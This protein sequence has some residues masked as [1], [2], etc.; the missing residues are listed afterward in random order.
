MLALIAGSGA[1]PAEL[2]RHQPEPPLVCALEGYAPEALAVDIW[3]RIETLGSLLAMLRERWIDEVCMAGAIRRPQVDPARIDAATMPFV[4]RLQKAI[5]SGD[6]GAL[7]AVIAIFEEA[8]FAVRGAHE[9][10]PDILPPVGCL[11]ENQPG[12]QDLDDA[13]RAAGILRAMSVAD[14]GQACVVLRG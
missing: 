9:I 7:R 6:D 11:T 4:P 1:L 3:F 2:A 10:A 5:M 8:G 12:T 14:V 13:A